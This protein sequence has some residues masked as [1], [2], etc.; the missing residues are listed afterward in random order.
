MPAPASDAI[1]S[2]V[3]H[4]ALGLRYGL[5]PF[6][7]LLSETV[8][9]RHLWVEMRPKTLVSAWTSDGG[10]LYHATGG[11][12]ETFDGLTLPVV[13]VRT[14][15]ETLVRYE[16]GRV[17]VAGTY[18][19]SES[20]HALYVYLTAG[21][22]P[23]ST[24]VVAEL[25]VHVGSHGVV[26]PILGPDRLTNGTLEA[27]TGT[28]PD[29]WSHSET[30]GVTL[31]KT[32][33]DPLQGEYAACL[34]FTAAVGPA[35]ADLYQDF[36]TLVAGQVY[37]ISG[38]Y[39]SSQPN[40]FAHLAVWDTAA[41]F[42]SS[43]GR[44]MSGIYA[45]SDSS[46]VEWRRFAFDFVCPSWATVR[47]QV[48]AR[49]PA[50][51]QSGTVDFDDVKL[52]HVQR[53][54]YHEPLLSADS[55]PTIEAARADAFWGEMSSALGSLSPLNGGGR[56]EP[57]IAAYDWLGADAIV[58]VG[59]RFQLG[60]NETLIEDCPIIAT[61]KLGA[62]TVTDSGVTFDL[63][64]DRKVL[65]LTL[66]LQRYQD[67]G[68]IGIIAADLGRYRPL[69]W[70]Q[71]EN[72][73]AVRVSKAGP[74]A[75]LGL[76]IYE[77]FSTADAAT[78]TQPTTGLV[79]LHSYVDETAAT[80]QNPLR[81]KV[82]VGPSGYDPP[83][84]WFSL[85]EDVRIIEVVAG[86]NDFLD[87]SI[88]GTPYAAVVAPGL[89][90][91]AASELGTTIRTSLNAVAGAGT[92]VTLPSYDLSAGGKVTIAKAAGT[93]AV[94][95]GTG[96]N[97][98]RSLWPELGFTSS[99]DVAAAASQTSDTGMFVDCDTQHILR[100]TSEGFVDDVSGTYTGTGYLNVALAPDIAHFILRV[101]LKV[102]AASI[103]T[104]SFVAARATSPRTCSL[105][106]GTSRTVAELFA[107]LETTGDMDIALEG[108]VW[109][110]RPRDT[111]TP[112]G[113]PSLVDA[114]FL[115]F[116]S[117]Y[118][119]DDLY[120]TVTL[121]YDESADGDSWRAG[122]EV[123]PAVGLR[124]GRANERTF[125]TCLRDEAEATTSP[126]SRLQ[127]ITVQAWTKRR[128]FRFSTKGK[129]LQVPVGGK[130]LLTRTK[131]LDTTGALSGLLVRVLSKRDDWAR[132]VSDVEAIEV[133]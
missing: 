110:C 44:T 32:M 46:A 102:P 104:A 4:G 103:D 20:T 66:P 128:R 105:Y 40:L 122:Q 48:T 97:K 127:E 35:G 65:A 76:G 75:N 131:G 49:T 94:L 92:F 81:R 38:A 86:E 74:G 63:E 17:L 108:G 96:A 59:G 45:M 78:Y 107:Q 61:G 87:F 28:V 23:A 52:Q 68:A 39:R 123:W 133:I 71:K 53:Y 69:L 109:Y 72:I 117:Y 132:W 30:A 130:L 5:R 11:V 79:E 95:T 84:G 16:A 54:A 42:L 12:A 91:W 26:H 21:A 67:L 85:Q 51:T 100:L 129:A 9:Q 2:D 22:S 34:T 82:L 80:E 33:S 106:V 62:P 25:G 18:S 3:G 19:W 120:Q 121:A 14:L 119:P 101:L 10:G 112:T 113:T 93:F 56:L 8:G 27:W 29:G 88:G 41:A 58:R 43:D 111:S 114:D 64:D 89:Y 15:T 55:V 13:G 37:R 50:G 47:V 126:S 125:E 99:A 98:D 118:D 124:H 83:T 60:G 6:R 90:W 7:D 57:L 70:G 36:T 73:R 116:E 24:T 1:A 77:V 31:D 115:S